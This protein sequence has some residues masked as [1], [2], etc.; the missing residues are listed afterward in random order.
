MG[1]IIKITGY[2]VYLIA[3]GWG[4]FICLTIISQELGFIGGC[5]AFMFF[6]VALA[7]APWYAVM[8]YGYW[9]PVFLIYGGGLAGTIL[10]GIGSLIDKD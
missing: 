6:P 2:L 5:I 8:K 10:Y 9:F 3:G 4:M 7:F 1:T